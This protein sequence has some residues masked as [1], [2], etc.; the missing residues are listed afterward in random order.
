MI[1]ALF[2]QRVRHFAGL[3]IVLTSTTF[4]FQNCSNVK[5]VEAA[6]NLSSELDANTA[7]KFGRT[8]VINPAYSQVAST[9]DIKVLLVVDNSPTMQNSQANLNKNLAALLG[10]IQNYSASVKVVSSTLFDTACSNNANCIS[11]PVLN[12][13]WSNTPIMLEGRSGAA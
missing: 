12:Y 8:Q 4:Y 9:G 2:S 3:I 11:K 7:N 5:F 10:Q 6:D 13:S 1:K